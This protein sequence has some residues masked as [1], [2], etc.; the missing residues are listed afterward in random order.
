MRWLFIIP[1]GLLAT[2]CFAMAI[3][4]GVQAIDLQAHALRIPGIVIGHRQDTCSSTD[5]NN[6]SISYTC[7]QNRVRYEVQGV[8]REALAEGERRR[9]KDNLGAGVKLLVDTRTE[10][11]R[12]HL[13]DSGPWIV[14]VLGLVFGTLCLG[15]GLIQSPTGEVI[16]PGPTAEV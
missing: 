5:K 9:E 3:V 15:S 7:F 4:F 1:L 10:P 12:V 2:G 14:P 8:T 13:E 16:P 6:R 11:F